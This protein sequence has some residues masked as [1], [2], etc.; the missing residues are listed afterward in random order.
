M[1]GECIPCIIDSMKDGTCTIGMYQKRRKGRLKEEQRCGTS[2]IF[3]NRIVF[4]AVIPNGFDKPVGTLLVNNDNNTTWKVQS[5]SLS[6]NAHT[7]VAVAV[8]V[9]IPDS[10]NITEMRH[11]TIKT[12]KLPSVWW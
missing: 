4:N 7:C 9:D 3:H 12:I 6:A 10:S 8:L 11:G 1:H 2:G 5:S